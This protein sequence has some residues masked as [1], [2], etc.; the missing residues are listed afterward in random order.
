MKRAY[1]QYVFQNKQEIRA[2]LKMPPALAEAALSRVVSLLPKSSHPDIGVEMV[3]I[4]I[5]RGLLEGIGEHWFIPDTK[6][7]PWLAECSRATA[8]DA[9]FDIMCDKT[10]TASP[11]SWQEQD[12]KIIV[13]HFPCESGLRSTAFHLAM[14]LDNPGEFS[15]VERPSYNR[16]AAFDWS[17]TKVFRDS[18]KTHH[19]K[20]SLVDFFLG[21]LLYRECFPETF[22]TGLPS[23]LQH[24]SHHQHKSIF[25]VG[26]SDK[27][28]LGGTHDSPTPHFRCG[29]FRVLKSE[30]FTHK[31]F[32]TV[33]VH[34]TF[35][36]G[37]AKTVLSPEQADEQAVR[38]AQ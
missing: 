11:E 33:F 7:V 6:L 30:K 31:R 28:K 23:D 26:V 1:T 14:C 5:E 4:G 19:A 34:E 37:Q 9:V 10:K 13:C 12:M 27:V 21:L 36:K 29:H 8:P 32:Q 15:L 16:S 35:V 2:L 22:L 17:N 24:P 20:G 3:C 25:T 38:E 18:I